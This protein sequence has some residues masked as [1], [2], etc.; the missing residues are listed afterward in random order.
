MESCRQHQGAK[1]LSD[2]YSVQLLSGHIWPEPFGTSCPKARTHSHT[3]ARSPLS[4]RELTAAETVWSD[5]PHRKFHKTISESARK[6]IHFWCNEFKQLEWQAQELWSWIVLCQEM[7]KPDVMHGLKG[8]NDKNFNSAKRWGYCMQLRTLSIFY[9]FLSAI[10]MNRGRV[11]YKMHNSWQAYSQDMNKL[12]LIWVSK[13]LQ[14]HEKSWYATPSVF[15][16]D[17]NPWPT[18]FKSNVPPLNSH[19]HQRIV[20]SFLVTKSQLLRNIVLC[21]VVI[22]YEWQGASYIHKIW[23]TKLWEKMAVGV[24]GRR[25]MM[26]GMSDTRNCSV[27]NGSD[28]GML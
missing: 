25:F 20:A 16:V 10:I 6:E 15:L 13:Y 14:C 3:T 17:L 9:F 7:S 19:I 4:D 11:L 5:N 24:K 18:M 21:V 22:W 28:L 8:E 26:Q 12:K 2:P 23:E 1:R 27:Q